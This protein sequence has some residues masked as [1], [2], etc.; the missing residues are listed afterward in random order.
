MSCNTRLNN[1]LEIIDTLLDMVNI[2]IKKWVAKVVFS[3]NTNKK[4]AI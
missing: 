1:S 3:S 2:E 4:C